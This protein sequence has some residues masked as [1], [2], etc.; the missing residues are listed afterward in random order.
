MRVF[1]GHSEEREQYERGLRELSMERARKELEA[2]RLRV[3]KGELKAGR[4]DRC[5]GRQGAGLPP[6]ES[7]RR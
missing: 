4:K 5:G 6:R 3:E 2:L 1:V 7:L